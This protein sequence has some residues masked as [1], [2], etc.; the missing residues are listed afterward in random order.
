[1][2]MAHLHGDHNPALEKFWPV[3]DN[4]TLSATR[5]WLLMQSGD[6]DEAKQVDFQEVSPQF[7]SD[8]APITDCH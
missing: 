5:Q 2:L 6:F 4:Y 1:M 8:A 7:D 3:L